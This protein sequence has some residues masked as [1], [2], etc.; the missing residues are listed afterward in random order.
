MVVIKENQEEYQEFIS[1]LLNAQQLKL[2]SNNQSI[3]KN[4]RFGG[5]EQK[6]RVIAIL[7]YLS[8]TALKPL[9]DLASSILRSIPNDQTYDQSKDLKYISTTFSGKHNTFYCFDLEAF[10][11]TFPINILVE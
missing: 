6:V 3:R 5:P 10:T 2:L 4:T 11:D 7:D 8:Q 1:N 9:H